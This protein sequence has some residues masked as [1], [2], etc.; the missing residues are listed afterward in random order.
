M[1]YKALMLKKKIKIFHNNKALFKEFDTYLKNSHI[2]PGTCADLTVTTLL[3][4]KIR[5]IFNIPL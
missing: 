4:N 1:K 5:D 2:N 3:I